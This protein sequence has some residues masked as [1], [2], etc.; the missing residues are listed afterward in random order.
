MVIILDLQ[1]ID[2]LVGGN[3]K[4]I[5]NTQGIAI[6]LLLIDQDQKFEEMLDT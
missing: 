6:F 1:L 4:Y 3:R 5:R 2:S